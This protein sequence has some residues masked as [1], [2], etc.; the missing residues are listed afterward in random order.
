MVT[1]LLTVEEAGMIETALVGA[2]QSP[3]LRSGLR[4]GASRVSARRVAGVLDELIARV[5]HQR[6]AEA[7]LPWPEP[8][9]LLVIERR[10]NGAQV[11]VEYYQGDQVARISAA[12]S[13]ALK[14]VPVRKT[15]PGVRRRAS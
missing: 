2:R 10:E 4:H 7:R 9:P 13:A 5:S 6:K 14:A 12:I 3:G 11:V 1:L 8:P 15:T